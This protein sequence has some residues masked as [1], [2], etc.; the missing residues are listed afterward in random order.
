MTQVARIQ[1]LEQTVGHLEAQ[2]DKLTEKLSY[3]EGKID[4]LL[5]TTTISD[6][7]ASTWKIALPN[8][9]ALNELTAKPKQNSPVKQSS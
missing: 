4:A 6:N 9:D 2:A 5:S 1:R 8:N 7:H 3:L